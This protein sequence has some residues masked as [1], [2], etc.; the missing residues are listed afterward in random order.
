MCI[1]TIIRHN[2]IKRLTSRQAYKLRQSSQSSLLLSIAAMKILSYFLFHIFM[3]IVNDLFFFSCVSIPWSTDSCACWSTGIE[4]MQ[5]CNLS[6]LCSIVRFIFC[7]NSLALKGSVED[8]DESNEGDEKEPPP[9]NQENLEELHLLMIEIYHWGCNGNRYNS[10]KTTTTKTTT[11]TTTMT[12]TT[13]L[14]R[15]TLSLMW[16]KARIQIALMFSWT[17]ALPHRQ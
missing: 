16:F 4:H 3:V 9:K 17:P 6:C 14:D 11:T 15:K 12:T 1:N 8:A 7:L 13:K 5:I 10:T 2:Q